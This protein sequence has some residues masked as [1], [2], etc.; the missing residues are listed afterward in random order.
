MPSRVMQTL[1]VIG[2]GK[3]SLF[4]VHRWRRSRVLPAAKYPVLAI[5]STSSSSC[6]TVRKV[7]VD[8]HVTSQCPPTFA[9]SLRLTISTLPSNGT[10]QRQR[11]NQPV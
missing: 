4:F 9:S 8:T 1:L 5:I 6:P 2:V 3:V 7:V 10:T 11:L